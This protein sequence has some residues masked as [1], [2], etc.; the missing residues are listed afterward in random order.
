MNKLIERKRIYGFTL[1]E[2]LVVISIIALLIAILMPAL[3]RARE[4]AKA[5][6]C[7]SNLKQMTT[8]MAMYAEAH[9]GAI[10]GMEY[11]EKYWFRQI[12]PYLGDKKFKYNPDGEKGAKGVMQIGICPNTKISQTSSS[13]YGTDKTTWRFSWTPGG[14]PQSIYGSY[15]ANSWVLEDVHNW[16]KDPSVKKEN[17]YNHKS[18]LSLRSEVPMLCDSLWVDSWPY[19]EDNPPSVDLKGGGYPGFP[20]NIGYFMG[21]FCVD[22]HNMA[23]NVGFVGTNVQKVPLEELWTLRW[24]KNFR[25]RFDVVMPTN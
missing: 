10:M 20:H 8:A 22:R 14:T 24:H 1:I 9:D 25:P 12:A 6:S 13:S 19:A 11:G 7:M 2:L 15:G 3:N 17:F 23:Q 18:Y 21:R 5:T 16:S 4:Q